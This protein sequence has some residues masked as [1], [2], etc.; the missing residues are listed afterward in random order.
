MRIFRVRTRTAN[1][2]AASR[3]LPEPSRSLDF[4]RRW[5]SHLSILTTPDR[6]PSRLRPFSGIQVSCA[7][8]LVRLSSSSAGS[9]S[10]RRPRNSGNTDRNLDMFG[11]GATSIGEAAAVPDSR[12]GRM[13][14][15][16]ATNPVAR[17]LWLRPSKTLWKRLVAEANCAPFQQTSCRVDNETK[18]SVTK[19]EGQPVASLVL[20]NADFTHAGDFP[21]PH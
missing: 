12:R 3:I 17:L 4:R 7:A 18:A 13:I 6:T 10:L 5:N 8:Q 16:S 1:H 9:S 2:A 14:R 21:S 11:P 15:C 19:E 20:A